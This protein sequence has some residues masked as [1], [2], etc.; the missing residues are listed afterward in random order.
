MWVDNR[1]QLTNMVFPADK[2]AIHANVVQALEC[3]RHTVEQHQKNQEERSV[4]LGDSTDSDLSCT[5]GKSLRF[6]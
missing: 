1:V 6:K 3:A 5:L 4:R 2:R